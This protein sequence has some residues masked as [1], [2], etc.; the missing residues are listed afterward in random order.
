[1]CYSTAEYC[2]AV[3]TRSSHAHKLDTE[4]NKVCRTITGTLRATPMTSLYRLVGIYPPDIRH[5]ANAKTERDKQLSDGHHPLCGHQEAHRRLRTRRNFTTV[6]CLCGVP[7][8]HFRPSKWR[9]KHPD[10]NED[11]L[12]DI[13]DSLPPGKDL[14][15]KDWVTL[16]RIQ[17]KVAKIGDN[18]VRWRIKQRADCACDEENQMI[19]H[20]LRECP[21]AIP[22][23]MMT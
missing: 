8:Q 16:N 23:Q 10:N 2:S 12:A 9:E 22:A 4:L 3:C 15:R 5:E 1:M 14:P 17:A 7:V 20:I 13:S 18:H 6:T 11:A 19:T 21:L